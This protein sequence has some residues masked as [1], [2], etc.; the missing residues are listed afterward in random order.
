MILSK[1]NQM[2]N[3]PNTNKNEYEVMVADMEKLA[4]RSSVISSK[5]AVFMLNTPN[6]SKEMG[7]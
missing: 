1:I 2:I 7:K 4:Q 6:I 5:M 3:E